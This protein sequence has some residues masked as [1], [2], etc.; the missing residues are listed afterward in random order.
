VGDESTIVQRK[1]ADNAKEQ[2][3]EVVEVK[4]K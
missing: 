1:V 2:L 3:W 4:A